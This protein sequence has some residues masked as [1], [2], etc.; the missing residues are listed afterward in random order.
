MKNVIGKIGI[1]LAGAVAVA[2]LMSAGIPSAEAQLELVPASGGSGTFANPQNTPGTGVYAGDTIYTYAL[3]IVNPNGGN[4]NFT[5]S[6]NG[7]VGSLN[8]VGSGLPPGGVADPGGYANTAF[9]IQDF[10]G[11]NSGAQGSLDPLGT[12]NSSVAGITSVSTVGSWD[13]VVTGSTLN[14][15][16]VGDNAI[17]SGAGYYNG[18]TMT[19]SGS[20]GYTSL[21]VKP[22][23][24]LTGNN[25]VFLGLFQFASTFGPG[26]LAFPPID[27]FNSYLNVG[28]SS[29]GTGGS[30]TIGNQQQVEVPSLPLPA[31]FWPGLMTLGGVAVIGG[32]RLRRRSV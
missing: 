11:Y 13:L 24:S 28:T 1:G 32:L 9:Q 30:S 10:Y 12:K 7:T 8:S 18:T 22:G 25:T 29:N 2:G 3:A 19:N 17:A 20:G 16:W 26:N 6:P 5:A 31:A 15:Y 23:S 4:Q 27:N 21:T 14:V